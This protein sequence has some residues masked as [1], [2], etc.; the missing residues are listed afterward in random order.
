MCVRIAG[1]DPYL[2][3]PSRD[4]PTGVLLWLNLRVF[5]EQAGSCQVFFFKDAPAE[6]NSVRIQV[7]ASKWFEARVPVP[8]LGPNYRL[9]IDPP[10]TGGACTFSH[11]WFEERV[12]FKT[13]QWAVPLAPVLPPDAPIVESG[14]LRLAHGAAL[15]AFAL[16]VQGQRVAIGNQQALIGYSLGQQLHWF[17]TDQKQGVKL[18]A[19]G[20]GKSLL[21]TATARDLHGA[22]WSFEQAFEAGS[23]GTIS[24]RG[25]IVVDQ[26]RQALY[27]PIITLLPGVG[28]WGT[29]KHQAVF[30]G[31]E[32]LENEPSSSEAD[33]EGPEARRLVPDSLKSTFP[34]MAIQDQGAYVGLIW[35]M[36]PEISAVFDSP[37]RQFRSGGHLMGLLFPGA[38]GKNRDPGS[39]LPYDGEMLRA[40]Q[41]LRF[42]ATIIG[43]VGDTIIPAVQQYVRLNPL[44]P[45]PAPGMTMGQYFGLASQGWLSSRVREA[46][47]YRHAYWPGFGAQPASD[48]ALWMQWLALRLEDRELGGR[49]AKASAAALNLVPAG[50]YNGSQ[51]GHVRFPLPA[52]VFGEVLENAANM[53]A[54][55]RALLGSF[56]P[57]GTVQYKKRDGSTDYGRTHG[58]NHANGLTAVTVMS[59]LENAVFCG[60]KQLI[61]DALRQ[62]QKLALYDHTVP[63]G[64][65]TW[66]IPL[67]TPDILASAY[68]VRAYTL[69]FE[70]TGD[71]SFRER[72][73]YWAWTGV[74]FVYLRNPAF[75]PI[76]PYATIPVLGAT[77]WKAPV[78][79]GLPV[80]WCGLVYADALYRFA[81]YDRTGP[82]RR[83]ADGITVSGIQ[84]TWPATDKERVG[85]LPDV[86]HLRQQLRDGP[87]I[88]PATLLIPALRYWEQPPPYTFRAFRKAGL[89]AHAP[90]E[91]AEI[92]EGRAGVSFQVRPWT[93]QASWVL[94]SGAAGRV[95]V[96]LNDEPVLFGKKHRYEERTGRLVIQI[97]GDAKLIVQRQDSH[98]DE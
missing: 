80:Q 52:L 71:E 53:E 37:D 41:P 51:I 31:V 66:E 93:K 72:A 57:D 40:G 98:P 12:L 23:A 50:N 55:G 91:L 32:Y 9:R 35:E 1:D 14:N 63:R 95:K 11:L 16:Q 21:V 34:L 25:S 92:S 28:S 44:P 83:L 70:L 87:A 65:Q 89:L 26:D 47:L 36:E 58:E 54:H 38:N 17:A 76:G 61:A 20:R 81:D 90:G 82:W 29:N 30:S 10:G 2:N 86:F 94:I 46:N 7:P 42:R 48:A 5:S 4:Y 77:A 3:G 18:V 96:T 84:Q 45:L 59:L 6:E 79:I 97:T 19:S 49:L 68:L 67:H 56:G 85:L 64:A 62:L 60:D 75:E 27:V 78:W 15:G 8:A 24:V 22:T 13:P 74:P 69:G 43:G 88:N 73:Q 39:L 33:L